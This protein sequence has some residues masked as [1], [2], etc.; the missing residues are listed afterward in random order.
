MLEAYSKNRLVWPVALVFTFFTWI[1]NGWFGLG[2]KAA[3]AV[4]LSP[5]FDYFLGMV[6][7]AAAVYM[8]A[9]LT[10]RYS[11]LG[12]TDRTISLTMMLLVAMST[13]LHPLQKAHV[14]LICYLISYLVLLGAYQS[15]QAP[16]AALS[17]NLLLGV[18]TIVC[19][20]L[21]WLV[22]VNIIS[23]GILRVLSL[24]TLIASLLGLAAPYWFWGVLAAWIGPEGTFASHL[25]LMTDFRP[26]G[27]ELLTSKESWSFWTALAMFVV[28]AVDFF[29]N[30]HLN[31]SRMRIDYYVV[32]W[33]GASA[34]FFL[35]L[36]PQLFAF[37]FPLAMVNAS[38]ACGHFTSF[39][40]GRIPDI[41]L[42]LILI[43]WLIATLFVG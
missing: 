6:V 33:Q 3:H 25:S 28:G 9:E 15:K 19:P 34:F 11:L 24:K 7:C 17:V 4:V 39:A 35:W 18:S 8:I 31:R 14:V 10:T 13:F 20:Q 40:K 26:G 22:F 42:S 21:V 43:L 23:L 16:V 37:L 29:L 38:I 30:I 1:M 5:F 12:N 27:L 32:C 36:E 2:G 41:L